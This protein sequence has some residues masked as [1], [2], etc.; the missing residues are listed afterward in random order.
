MKF[1]MVLRGG[2][3]DGQNV[4]FVLLHGYVYV[5]GSVEG[6]DENIWTSKKAP[7]KLSSAEGVGV[8]GSGKETDVILEW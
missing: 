1:V 8:G 6:S 2:R 3:G 7:A 5:D 4:M